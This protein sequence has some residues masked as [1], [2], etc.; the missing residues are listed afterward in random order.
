MTDIIVRIPE[1]QLN[2]FQDDKLNSEIAFWRF[3][4][5]PKHL[6]VGDF[7]WFTRPVGL[8]GG[9]KVKEITERDET[10]FI[11]TLDRVGKW[12]LL[13][14]GRRTRIF[15][16]PI[17]DIQYAQQGYRYVTP[18]EQRRLR[19]AYEDVDK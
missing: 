1:K 17:P 7:I 5:K 10:G 4:N 8:I 11:E 6:E 2:H 3:A 19:Q 18:E 14:E 12:N 15:N 13:W 16:T 9:A